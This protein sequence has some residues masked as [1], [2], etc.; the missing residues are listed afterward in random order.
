MLIPSVSIAFYLTI[1]SKLVIYP[2]KDTIHDILKRNVRNKPQGR[3]NSKLFRKLLNLPLNCL[4]DD[5]FNSKEVKNR[6]SFICAFLKKV[7]IHVWLFFYRVLSY[8]SFCVVYIHYKDCFIL[9][10][11]WNNVVA[12]DSQVY[13]PLTFYILNLVFS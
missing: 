1:L 11:N 4:F 10:L 12:T 13:I 5:I 9:L 8:V 3:Q 7:G 6:M 2:K